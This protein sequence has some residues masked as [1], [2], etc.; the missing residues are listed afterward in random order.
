VTMN[1]LLRGLISDALKILLVEMP[2]FIKKFREVREATR[3]GH[4]V[5]S[6]TMDAVVQR[7]E[8]IEGAIEA[9]TKAT[10]DLARA[11]VAHEK[12]IHFALVF[13]VVGMA[14][15]IAVAV[16]AWWR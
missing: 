11:V 7:L 16:L 2:V 13:A 1:P 10:D 12:R 9:L 6:P 8:A 4:K 5:S 14:L 15:A 3:H